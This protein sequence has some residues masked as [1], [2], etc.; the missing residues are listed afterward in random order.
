MTE[1]PRPTHPKPATK[2]RGRLARR[3]YPT[4]WIHDFTAARLEAS[5]FWIVIF[6]HG[7]NLLDASVVGMK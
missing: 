5:I 6:G 3:A 2:Q 1:T 7:L 4:A